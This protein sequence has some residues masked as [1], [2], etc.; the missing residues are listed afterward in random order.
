M[1]AA[2]EVTAAQAT[3]A[4]GELLRSSG[5]S[6]SWHTPGQAVSPSLPT[7]I[8]DTPSLKAP[9]RGDRSTRQVTG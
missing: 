8:C 1:T 2:D 3:S 4:L 9:S 7:P 6:A 5:P